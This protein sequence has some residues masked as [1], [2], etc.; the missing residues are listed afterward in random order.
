MTSVMTSGL[1]RLKGSG[2]TNQDLRSK[3][4]L[5]S[6]DGLKLLF[7]IR[8]KVCEEPHRILDTVMFLHSC[9][10]EPSLH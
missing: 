7:D 4:F 10:L 5:V 6:P 2:S 9:F 1:S 3:N 8:H